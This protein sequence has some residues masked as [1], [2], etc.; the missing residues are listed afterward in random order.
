MQAFDVATNIENGAVV[1]PSHHLPRSHARLLSLPQPRVR[2][3]G[4]TLLPPLTEHTVSWTHLR[5]AA[6][7]L[8][9][10][11]STSTEK[12]YSSHLRRR[13]TRVGGQRVH[14][15]GKPSAVDHR[16]PTVHPQRTAA[17]RLVKTKIFKVPLPRVRRSILDER[18]HFVSDSNYTAAMTTFYS[19]YSVRWRSVQQLRRDKCRAE[20][21]DW[22]STNYRTGI[23]TRKDSGARR[24]ILRAVCSGEED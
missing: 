3:R 11:P 16:R 10:A 19:H 12:S 22:F 13:T 18:I 6:A 4:E 24:G 17:H 1:F 7:H 15:P 23:S 21:V 9:R 8:G 20:P 2:V 14:L 5:H